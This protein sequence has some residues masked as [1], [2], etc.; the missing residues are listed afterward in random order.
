MMLV[1]CGRRGKTTAAARPRCSRGRSGNG[2]AFSVPGTSVPIAG[3]HNFG[4]P[5]SFLRGPC[6]RSFLPP[7]ILR[8]LTNHG[9]R[10]GIRV[11]CVVECSLFEGCFRFLPFRT[12]RLPRRNRYA[13]DHYFPHSF[14]GISVISNNSRKRYLPRLT[15]CVRR[16]RLV[17]Q[18]PFVHHTSFRTRSCHFWIFGRTVGKRRRR[19]GSPQEI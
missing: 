11:F 6:T 9:G 2:S 16:K 3:K 12:R 18:P 13:D 7:K 15:H 10:R 5:F 14:Y 8:S 4:I 17:S 19:Q 1:L